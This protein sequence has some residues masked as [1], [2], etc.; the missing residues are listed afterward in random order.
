MTIITQILERAKTLFDVAGFTM[1][2][3]GTLLVLGLE[4]TMERN[5][6]D[7]GHKNGNFRMYGFEKFVQHRLDELLLFIYDTGCSAQAVGR[8]G[9]P[10]RGEINLKEAAIHIGI[11]KRG[12]NTVVLHPE[13]GPRLRFMGII[14]DIPCN[15]PEIDVKEEENP[16]CNTCTICI[17]SCPVDALE[18]YYMPDPS[19]CLSNITPVDEEGHSILCDLCLKLC[20]AGT[21]EIK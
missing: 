19:V 11:G 16:T 4:S 14:T 2:K 13:Y 3:S 9:Y 6:D 5:L 21:P 17:D 15:V 18:P 1:V 10:L 20:P 7:F 8:I 12:K